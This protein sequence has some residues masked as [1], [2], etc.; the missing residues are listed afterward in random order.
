MRGSQVEQEKIVYG[1]APLLAIIV[2]RGIS[3]VGLLDVTGLALIIAYN[4]N[5][6]DQD[7]VLPRIG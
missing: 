2:I 4:Q 3:I 6:F 5:E 1:L 7:M